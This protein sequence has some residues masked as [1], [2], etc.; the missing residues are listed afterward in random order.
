M[1]EPLPLPTLP[2]MPPARIAPINGV[3]LAWYEIGERTGVPVIF[4]H[5]FPELAFSW[6]H[7]LAALGDAGRWAIA[8]DQRGYGLSSRPSDIT[9]YDLEHLTD[10]L[11]GLLDHLGVEKAIFCGHDWGGFVVW[12]MG[13]RHPHRCAG[14]VAL[15]TPFFS[16]GP[17]DPVESLRQAQG[18]DTYV[19]YFQTPGVADA[20]LARD[21][22]RSLRF[23]LRGPDAVNADLAAPSPNGS[24]FTLTDVLERY[25]PA[26]D[27]SQFLS[28]EELAVFVSAFRRTGFT[29]ALNWYRNLS[30]NWRSAANLPT[31]I[32]AI[33]CLMI[34]AEKDAL[35]P[36]AYTHGMESRI[37]DLEK[38]LVEGAGHWTQQERPAAVNAFLIDWLDRRFP[39]LRS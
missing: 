12:E 17:L 20:L 22:W 1:I 34:M 35:L 39:R 30:R 9:A 31:R 25:D 38:V 18:E 23:I 33:P 7:Q 10:D 15:N 24:T 4:C 8:I 5:G 6:R 16:R 37:G 36:P 11:V 26:T 13:L 32:D 28:D 29:G 19:V 2:D 27:D 21:P 3:E 14:I